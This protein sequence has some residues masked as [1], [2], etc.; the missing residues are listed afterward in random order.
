LRLNVKLFHGYLIPLKSL[1]LKFVRKQES[2]LGDVLPTDSTV[3][4]FI[5][6]ILKVDY[7][8]RIVSVLTLGKGTQLAERHFTMQFELTAFGVGKLIKELLCNHED[9]LVL[10]SVPVELLD[11]G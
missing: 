10:E 2:D 4:S 5:V 8:L 9:S 3:H 6:I 7:N 11:H 1:G